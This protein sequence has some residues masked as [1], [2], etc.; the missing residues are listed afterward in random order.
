MFFFKENPKNYCMNLILL[1]LHLG[2]TYSFEW[3][4]TLPQGFLFLYIPKALF[5]TLLEGLIISG[6]KILSS[7]LSTQTGWKIMSI[8]FAL[9]MFTYKFFFQLKGV[10][11]LKKNILFQFL[12]KNILPYKIRGKHK[13]KIL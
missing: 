10:Y 1:I 6:L 8:L 7:F 13:L 11:F 5:F 4:I 3:V 9:A 2:R 12:L